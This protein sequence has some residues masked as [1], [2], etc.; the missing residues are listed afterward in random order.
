MI[1]NSD[2]LIELEAVRGM[3]ALIVV[4]HHSLLAFA[5]RLEGL[6]FPTERFGLFGTPFYAFVNGAASV[7]LFFVLSGFVL[8]YKAIEIRNTSGIGMSALKRWPRLAGPVAIVNFVSGLLVWWGMYSNSQAADIARSPWLGWWFGASPYPQIPPIAALQEGLLSTFL[9]GQ[10]YFN[11]NLWTMYYEFFGSFIALAL[12]LIV[13]ELRR[14][15]L[16]LLLSA[17]LFI[18]TLYQSRFFAPFVAGVMVAQVY[19]LRD[20]CRIHLPS[21]L[22]CALSLIAIILFGFKS[23]FAGDSIGFYVRIK[24]ITGIPL[25]K[26]E[27]LLH[28]VAALLIMFIVMAYDPCRRVLNRRAGLWLGR[29]SFPIYLTHLLV[30]CTI[31]S[32][33]FIA[34]NPLLPHSFTITLTLTAVFGVTFAVS[35]PL[36]ILDGIWVRLINGFVARLQSEGSHDR[37]SCT[38]QPIMAP[39]EHSNTA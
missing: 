12:A 15:W 7:V 17:G 36:A 9:D 6:F 37:T 29:M 31:G 34:I 39:N 38:L 24:P 30:I 26:I 16:G 10:Y 8:T 20:R 14:P 18:L 3:A 11:S 2:K 22:A 33:T 19:A 13:I 27:L 21:G 23:S 25:D 5:P 28:T 4:L 1:R 35:F 32:S